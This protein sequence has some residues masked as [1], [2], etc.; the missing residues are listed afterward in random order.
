MRQRFAHVEL[1]PGISSIQVAC[2][3]LGLTVEESLFITLHARDG[4][5]SALQEAVET[6]RS[7][8]RHVFLLPRP[9]DMMPSAVAGELMRQWVPSGVE[10]FVLERLT[11]SDECISRYTLTSLAD[12]DHEFSD[13]SI[14]VI[15][16]GPGLADVG[17]LSAS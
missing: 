1:L 13:L 16:R 10:V 9:W 3:R 17:P 5:E 4:Y 7:G 8:K 12:S 15:P 14:M 2:A 6:I 11:L